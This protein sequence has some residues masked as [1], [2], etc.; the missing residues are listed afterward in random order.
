MSNS[1]PIHRTREIVVTLTGLTCA[2]SNPKT[3]NM[4]Q[5]AILSRRVDPVTAVKTGADKAVC[6]D[7]PLRPILARMARMAR[8]KS[9]RCYVRTAQFPLAVWRAVRGK[10]VKPLSA[11]KLTQGKRNRR[12]ENKPVRLGAYGDPVL[13]PLPMLAELTAGRRHTGYT[14][15]HRTC[16]PAYSRYLMA[17]CETI[18]DVKDAV[19]RGWRTF[20]TVTSA[21]SQLLPN[22]IVCPNYANK[23]ITCANCGLCNGAGKAKNIAIPVHGTQA[24]V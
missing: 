17:S 2:S 5:A 6:G 18:E 11:L 1:V 15:Q 19:K 3:G 16:D 24:K 8:M 12:A 23:A 7:C 14:H 21:D 22:E 13:I 10:R 20:R 4:L 9:V